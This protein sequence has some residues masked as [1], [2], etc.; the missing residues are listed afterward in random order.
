MLSKTKSARAPSRHDV[1]HA[2]GRPPWRPRPRPCRPRQPAVPGRAPSP[3][4]APRGLGIL[5]AARTP[6]TAP[7]RPMR[8]PWTASYQP[9]RTP[10]T[11]PYR[12]VRTADRRSVGSTPLYAHRSRWPCYGGI[13][14]VT[15]ASPGALPIK[16]ERCSPLLPP[17]LPR[18]CAI[19]AAVVELCPPCFPR[20]SKRAHPFPRPFGTLRCHLLFGPSPRRRRSRAT[21]AAAAGF[22]RAPTPARSPPQRRSPTSPR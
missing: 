9:V 15:A 1:A 11:A 3:C 19:R 6:W 20:S 2:S 5:P 14:V 4:A 7:Y 13:F 8:M 16:P 18:R 22:R 12:S 17:P 21:A 10:W